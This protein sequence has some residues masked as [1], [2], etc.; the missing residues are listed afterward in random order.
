MSFPLV[1]ISINQFTLNLVK[2]YKS[3]SKKLLLI[4]ANALIHRAFHALPP[5]ISSKGEPMGALYGLA[6]T[7]LKILSDEKP[8]YVAAV[9]DTP[10]ETF[11]KKEYK[12]YKAHR[13]KT[14][15]ELISQLIRA[16]KLFEQFGIPTMEKGGFEADDILGT[17]A[18]KFG[19]KKNLQIVILTGD[20]DTLQLVR[21]DKIIVLTPKKGVSEMVLYDERRVYDRFGLGPLKIPDY[22]GLVGDQSDNIPGVPG[23]GPKTASALLKKFGSLEK[24]IES[25]KETDDKAV[26]KV[27]ENKKL[28]L[29]SKKLAI[30]DCNV[31]VNVELE[32]LSFE[33][34]NDNKLIEYFKDMG[35]KALVKR[36][37]GNAETEKPPPGKDRQ[38][39]L[40]S[41]GQKPQAAIFI[42]DVDAYLNKPPRFL[43]STE[44]K[45]ALEWKPFIKKLNQAGIT[46]KDPIFDIK[47][48]AWLL[49]PDKEEKELDDFIKRSPL[50]EV[51]IALSQK[52]RENGLEQIFYN[53]EMPLIRILAEMER[54]GVGVDLKRIRDMTKKIDAEL[55]RLIKKIYRE[56]DTIFNINSPKQVGDILFEKIG[57][58]RPKTKTATGQYRT[59]EKVLVSLKGEHPVVQLLLD[60]RELFKMKS[61]YLVPLV[62]VAKEERV[63]T[64]F[65]QT[66]T[67]TGRLAS[68]DP[69]LQNIPKNTKWATELRKAFRADDGWS[70]LSFDYSQLELRLL[71]HISGEPKLQNAFRKGQDIHS[72]TASSVFGVPLKKVSPKERGVAK[73][74]NFG[75]I[76]GMGAR[77]FSETSGLSLQESKKFID[78]YFLDFPRVKKWQEKTV[79]EARARGFVTNL[80]GRR[81]L[82]SGKPQ[83]ERAIINMPIQSLEADIIKT[84]M[85]KVFDALKGRGWLGEKAKLIL[86]IHDELLLEVDDGILKGVVPLLKNIL[87]NEVF[88]LSV[89]LVVD[90]SAGKSWGEMRDF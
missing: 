28:A 78:E 88:S 48:A 57:L 5:L 65:L 14:P 36:L 35:F 40:F 79:K 51:Y 80:N 81:R 59:S 61:T 76:Y 4:D 62:D 70:L 63:H 8:D 47:I 89:P 33:K 50:E 15:D 53:I 42:K 30:I 25:K 23:V 67:A 18:K 72:L 1:H 27:L 29:L 71:A 83:M 46:V 26:K 85:I 86:S 19:G 3:V 22:K 60:Y 2:G 12:E 37:G 77:A 11:R 45:V 6:N 56:A 24:I 7:L 21:G 44:T 13:P 90:V 54:W 58:K 55:E 43:D 31:D 69:N 32:S 10:E 82:F 34:S 9:F 20:L 52:I 73:T 41:T 17:L 16:H 66:S 49:D 87:E 64:T 75:I 68:K 38:G 39:A 74:L 84:G